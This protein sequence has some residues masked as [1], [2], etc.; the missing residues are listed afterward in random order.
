MGTF[1]W[2][3]KHLSFIIPCNLVTD[4]CSLAIFSTSYCVARYI[5]IGLCNKIA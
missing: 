1:D 4:L 2:I 3:K 5:A